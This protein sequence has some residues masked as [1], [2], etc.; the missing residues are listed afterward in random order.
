VALLRESRRAEAASLARQ[1]QIPFFRLRGLI[2]LLRRRTGR[3]EMTPVGVG[4]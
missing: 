1:R 4:R 3:W 2:D